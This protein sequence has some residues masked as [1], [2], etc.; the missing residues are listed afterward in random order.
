MEVRI[1]RS[2]EGKSTWGSVG[3]SGFY[4]REGEP[5]KCLSRGKTWS[6]SGL[7]GMLHEEE[8][9]GHEGGG[10]ETQEAIAVIQ[11]SHDGGWQV[12]HLLH[13]CSKP[14]DLAGL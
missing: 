3:L 6:G 8:T 1:Q 10:Q 12:G 13:G 2:R 7:P 4:A 14:E 5:W 9:K 11:A